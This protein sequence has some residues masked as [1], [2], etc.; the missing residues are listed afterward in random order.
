MGMSRERTL[1]IGVSVLV[2]MLVSVGA[3]AFV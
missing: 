1:A 3:E 2:A